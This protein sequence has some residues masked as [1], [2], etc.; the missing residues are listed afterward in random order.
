MVSAADA[1]RV[2]L[3]DQAVRPV[4]RTALEELHFHWQSGLSVRPLSGII[5]CPLADRFGRRTVLTLSNFRDGAR[6]S[7]H[8]PHPRLR[9]S[10]KQ[11]RFF[12]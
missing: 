1:G 5:I 2:R 6:L 7:D 4:G 11:H 12:F 3:N 9:R 8:R 10:A